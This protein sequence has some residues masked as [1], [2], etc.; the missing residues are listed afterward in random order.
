MLN[1]LDYVISILIMYK[2]QTFRLL[3][4]YDD[5]THTV[6]CC[7]NENS[8]FNNFDQSWK[9]AQCIAHGTLFLEGSIGTKLVDPIL[10]D[11]HF[12][13]CI[14]STNF[15]PITKIFNAEKPKKRAHKQHCQSL[16]LLELGR[17][18]TPSKHAC[19]PSL[20]KRGRLESN[21]WWSAQE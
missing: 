18:F 11:E 17:S 19:S 2:A 6:A 8:N 13:W 5:I 12:S 15:V 21:W 3:S 9:D 16:K 10:L 20:I 1:S 7:V 4:K 14:C